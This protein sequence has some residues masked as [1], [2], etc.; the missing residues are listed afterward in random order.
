MTDGDYKH[1]KC[2][3]NAY[4]GC[5]T[6]ISGEHYI[7]H[8]IIKLY[9]FDDPTVTI[10]HDHG[11]GVSR[12]VAPA[13]FVGNVLCR[14]HNSDFHKLDDEA[15]KFAKFLHDLSLSW[16]GGAGEWGEPASV[17]ISGEGF[18]RWALKTL[19]TAAA[20]KIYAHDGE[21]IVSPIPRYVVDLLLDRDE[22]PQTGGL[23]VAATNPHDFLELDPFSYES[24]VTDWCHSKPLFSN[25]DNQLWGGLVSL[26]GIGFG[27]VLDDRLRRPPETR[28]PLNPFRSTLRKPGFLAWDVGG[29]VKEINF[30]WDDGEK[31][32]GI[33]FH[34][35]N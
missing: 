1:P 14:T 12:P 24:L 29:V 22:W 2:Y 10:M 21:R 20:A 31:H 35:N 18:Q 19:A 32:E 11:F 16:L 26:S 8:S 17:D 28:N 3:V 30:L 9:T 15:L 6:K 27:V 13:R 23:C 4:G 7:P 5:S 34:L 25:P 33:T